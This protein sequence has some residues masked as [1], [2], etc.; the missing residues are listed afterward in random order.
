MTNEPAAWRNDPYGRF[1]LRYWDGSRW[2]EHVSTN[3]EQ[4][5]DPL[6]TSSVV[7]FVLPSTAAPWPPPDP[8]Q[9]R[10]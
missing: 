8:Q 3:G 9:R 10:G 4:L 7:P 2:T 1:Q 6:G 5:V